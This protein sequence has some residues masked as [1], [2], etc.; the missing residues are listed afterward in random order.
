MPL[1]AQ[2][3]R[4]ARLRSDEMR[5]AVG[6]ARMARW[7]SALAARWL[8]LPH[9]PPAARQQPAH[10]RTFHVAVDGTSHSVQLSSGAHFVL[11]AAAAVGPAPVGQRDRADMEILPARYDD[12]AAASARDYLMRS[13]ETYT[14]V[15][16]AGIIASEGLGKQ[17]IL[18]IDGSLHGDLSHIASAPHQ[19]SWGGSL[20]RLSSLLRQSAALHDQAE[21]SDLWL[22]GIGKTQ[23]ASFLYQALAA[24]TAPD[25]D[26]ERGAQDHPTDG[27][28]LGLA[29]TGW[30][31]PLMLD[32]R[33]F[34]RIT[35]E[36]EQALKLCPAIIS[37]YVRP[38]P[39]DL[40][41]RIDVPASA[42]GLGDRL[43]PYLLDETPTAWPAWVPD[44]EVVRPVVEAVVAAYGGV[45]AYNG[46]LYAVDRLVRLPRR[47]L[48]MRYLPMCAKVAGL[49]AGALSV[50]RGR[51]RFIMA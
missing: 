32:Y 9:V 6:A 1:L 13:L 8:P 36:A 38:H 15:E 30:T 12:S 16:A 17:T 41:L 40:P 51:R 43:L 42:C 37:C 19:M 27:E 20:A 47:D 49:P 29:A 24:G 3:I 31:W 21:Q 4:A 5:R 35:P 23:R 26:R 11:A 34:S 18:W 22:V 10:G 28:L 25:E 45:R 14:A 48:E 7:R 46:P 50:D 2:V 39:A 33:Q 44:P